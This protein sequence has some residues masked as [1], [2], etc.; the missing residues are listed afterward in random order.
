MVVRSQNSEVGIN[1]VPV[2]FYNGLPGFMYCFPHAMEVD[3]FFLLTS[4]SCILD[5][6]YLAKHLP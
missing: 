2:V 6:E 3:N 1:P 4:G 5:A